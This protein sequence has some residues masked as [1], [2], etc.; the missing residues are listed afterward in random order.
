MICIHADQVII[1]NTD[2]KAD[3]GCKDNSGDNGNS[4]N[5]ANTNVTTAAPTQ[6]ASVQ[7]GLRE[8]G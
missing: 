7:N 8:I 2:E 5:A 1:Y 3:C 6:A 4:S